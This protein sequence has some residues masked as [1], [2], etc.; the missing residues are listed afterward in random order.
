MVWKKQQFEARDLQFKIGLN[1]FWAPF[2]LQASHPCQ[3]DQQLV[4]KKLWRDDKC[5]YHPSTGGLGL[6]RPHM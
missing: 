3:H 6:V 1:K 2:V 5:F 4:I